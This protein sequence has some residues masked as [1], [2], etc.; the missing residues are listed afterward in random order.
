L[1]YHIGN[2]IFGGLLPLIG[3]MICAATG[4]IYAGLIY[5]IAVATITLIVGSIFLKETKH[6]RIWDELEAER[7]HGAD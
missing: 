7:V 3:L 4:N 6:V 2:G 5:P 1:P